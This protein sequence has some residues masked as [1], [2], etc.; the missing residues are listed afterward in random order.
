MWQALIFF[1]RQ[2][3][4]YRWIICCNQVNHSALWLS[5]LDAEKF[6]Q[7][8]LSIPWFVHL[9]TNYAWTLGPTPSLAP[10]ILTAWL[11]VPK[12]C[13]KGHGVMPE[14][15]PLTNDKPISKAASR[16]RIIKVKS[17]TF[18][19]HSVSLTLLLSHRIKGLST[20]NQCAWLKC[21]FTFVEMQKAT[22]DRR[23]E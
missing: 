12:S 4:L 1:V 6:Q 22:A 15:T 2:S 11:K 19:S 7:Q 18:P 23:L 8:I 20:E 9:D 14:L 13:N 17:K 3:V 5:S 16:L 10:S 21:D